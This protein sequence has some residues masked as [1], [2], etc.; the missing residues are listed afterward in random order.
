M[1]SR[2]PLV[3]GAKSAKVR[4]ASVEDVLPATVDFP[5]GGFGCAEGY[6]G[7]VSRPRPTSM[8]FNA[9]KVLSAQRSAGAF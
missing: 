8:S 9:G 3:V 6:R 1:R 2:Y 4:A 7:L 5:A